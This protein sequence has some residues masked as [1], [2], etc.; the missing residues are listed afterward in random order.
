MCIHK[1]HS[2]S[3][4]CM[5]AGSVVSQARLSRGGSESLACETTHLV[6]L[7]YLHCTLVWLFIRKTP[8][9]PLLG[10]WLVGTMVQIMPGLHRIGIKDKRQVRKYLD[11]T[12]SKVLTDL[13]WRMITTFNRKLL[14]NQRI[15]NRFA[16]NEVHIAIGHFFFYNVNATVS[17]GN[18][19]SPVYIQISKFFTGQTN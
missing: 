17:F 12:I 10:L 19:L 14:G 7:F 16:S 13:K 8:H 18:R 15:Q 9:H 1:A 5:H 4:P 2:P 11:S 6:Q 3:S